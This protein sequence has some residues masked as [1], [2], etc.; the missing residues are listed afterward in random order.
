MERDPRPIRIYQIELL[1]VAG[2]RLVFRVRCSKGTYIRTLVEDIAR[3]AGTVAYTGRLHRE[4]VGDFPSG[5]MMDLDAAEALA[6]AGPEPLRKRLM[7]ADSALSGLP[8]VSL[9]A[10][11]AERFCGGQVVPASDGGAKGLARVYGA[12]QDF[13][14][15]GELSGDGQVAPRRVFRV[16]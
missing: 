10:D 9:E 5:Q 7:P 2:T 8:G 1:E 15:V 11:Q 16:A 3:K 4:T 13:L 12:R 14:G 6:E